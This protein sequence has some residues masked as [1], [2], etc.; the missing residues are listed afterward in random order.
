[1]INVQGKKLLA[2]HYIWNPEFAFAW[3]SL[4]ANV[5]GQVGV[6]LAWGGGAHYAQHGV[7]LVKGGISIATTTSGKS[8]GSGGHYVKTRVA[9]PNVAELVA[10]ASTPSRMRRIPR[11]P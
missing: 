11:R 4:A 5:D 3:P 7:G 6:S 2:Q 8:A 9:F 10:G 1:V